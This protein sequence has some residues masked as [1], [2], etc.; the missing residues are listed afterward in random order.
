MIKRA[1]ISVSSKDGI[2]DFAKAIADLGIEIISTG[3]TAALLAANGIQV[4]L[5]SD[6]TGF[7]EILDG[8]VKT[9]QPSIHGG[10]LA[11]RDNLEH[12]DTIQKHQILPIDMVVVNLYPFKET[13]SK[14]NVLLSEAIEN[15]D[16][17]GP[18][19]I[20]SAAKNYR[21]V[22]VLVNPAAYSEVIQSI[23]DKGDTDITLRFRLAVEA[24]SHTGQYDALI[25]RYLYLQD[26]ESGPFPPVLNLSLEKI[27]DLH[28]GENP[29]QR[30]AF[31][32]EAFTAEPCIA[33]A[34]QLHG[35]DLSYNNVNDANAALELVKEFVEPA[36][37]AVKHANPCGVGIGTDLCEAYQKAF[38]SDPISIFGGIIAVNRT[39]DAD[40]ARE[41]HKIFVE[42]VIAPG[43][44]PEAIAI[45]TQ[46]KNIRIL[47][48]GPFSG[49]KD[50][51][52][53]DMKKVNGGMLVQDADLA[54]TDLQT[55]VNVSKRTPN[56]TELADLE[57]AWKVVKHTKSNAI[58][59]AKN[60][61]TVG[62][63]AGQM[64]RVGSA[65]IAAEQA[66][67]KARGAVMASDAFFPFPDSVEVAVRAGVTAIAHP[68]GSV[69]D[70]ESIEEADRA[71]VAML[72]TGIRHFRH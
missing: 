6:L 65:R 58:I 62:I 34:K 7:P 19:M 59:F 72:I 52:F 54:L 36:V 67:E 41:I 8:R 17:G 51:A 44:T 69:K 11:M 15:I 63:G 22:T 37:V 46:K 31:Y 68:G 47:D 29:H 35:R 55:W 70:K 43:Y 61:G 25:S 32:K 56:Q 28:Y 71:G 64:N 40:C 27:S 60:G 5:V 10:I 42:I 30:G 3:G 24:F 53:W 2:V 26:P 39:M 57:F 16:I 9:L 33:N 45:L 21:D 38:D 12:M 18:A 23:K 4:R 14:P 1:L 50:R 49:L 48:V 66:G 13:I 20:R